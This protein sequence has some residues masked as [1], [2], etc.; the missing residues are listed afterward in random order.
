VVRSRARERR[1]SR[2]RHVPVDRGAGGPGRLVGGR[3][4]AATIDVEREENEQASR[5][6]SDRLRQE[7]GRTVVPEEQAPNENTPAP[8]PAP[9]FGAGARPMSHEPPSMTTILRRQWRGG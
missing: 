4:I 5:D 9:D 2:R 3:R 1:I 7:A 8:T 6:F